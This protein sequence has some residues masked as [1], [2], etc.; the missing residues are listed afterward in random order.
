[1]SEIPAQHGEHV[2]GEGVPIELQERAQ[3]IVTKDKKPV[4]PSSDWTNPDRQLSFDRALEYARQR[5]AELGFALHPEDPFVVIDFDQVGPSNA[6][7]DTVD[8]WVKTFDT[9]TEISRSGTGLHLVCEGTR[10][11][12]RQETG[13]LDCP[14]TVDIFDAGQYIVLTG[15]SIGS[16]TTITDGGDDLISFQRQHLPK[17][18]ELTSD[19]PKGDQSKTFTLEEQS[20]TTLNF[21]P[22]DIW[23]TIREYAA[24]GYDHEQ[25]LRLSRSPA[26]SDAGQTSPSEADLALCS[27]LAFWCQEDAQLMDQCFRESNRHREKWD[28]IHYAD[29]RTYG[30]GTIQTAIQSNPETYSANRYVIWE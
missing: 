10:L 17:R 12:D 7:P 15:D 29:G 11:P 21:R 28:E 4:V 22:T 2:M 18:V 26:G 27:H 16:T 23:R 3:W 19:G 13:E 9:Y 8:D 24:A 14:G 25:V 6:L 5:D 1:M 30:E 20:S